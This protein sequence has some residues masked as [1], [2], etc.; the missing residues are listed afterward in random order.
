MTPRT[1]KAIWDDLKNSAQ[2]YESPITFQGHNQFSTNACNIHLD[3]SSQKLSAE[4][5]QTLFEL[6]HVCQFSSNIRSMMRGDKLNLS[7][8]RPALHTALRARP[9]EVIFVDFQNIVPKVLA[10]RNQIETIAE[11]IRAKRWFG[12]SGKPIKDIVNVGIGGS[13][14]G[15]YFAIHA[16]KN[17]CTEELGYH[18]IS[19]VSPESFYNVIEK[20]NP[21]TTLFIIS[22]KSFTTPE[23]IHNAQKAIEWIGQHELSANHFIAITACEDK[24]RQ[25]GIKNIIPI[26]DWVGG[27]F[28]FCSAI[29]L[30]TA[31]AI[32][33]EQF[34]SLI[35]GAHQ[36]DQHVLEADDKSNMPLLLALIGIWNINF[37]NIPSLVILPYA[38]PFEFFVPFIQQMDMESN[39][40]SID[41][42]GRN[43][44]HA[45][46]PIIW[47]G[48]GNNAQHSY[49]QLLCQG[50]HK[51][52]ADFISLTCH[53]GELI[54]S[55]CQSRMHVLT[56]GRKL[57]HQPSGHIQGGIPLNHIQLSDCTPF[58]IGA[59][60]AL[61]E[62]KIFIQSVVWNTNPFDQP[63]VE[64]AKQEAGL[65][66]MV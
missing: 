64:S 28:S 66:A 4:I 21:E 65:A 33:A 43:I 30:I 31:I 32:G 57:P 18:F 63:G 12:F 17:F 39:G 19:D 54:N 35:N 50:T 56:H 47:G 24:A 41:R 20:L 23:T 29:N 60:V 1:K 27:R 13:H 40:K 16:L 38:R 55:M 8:Q 58:T 7:E 22:S 42:E 34:N 6:A 46:S 62:H 3:Y 36:M 44:P 5:L 11:L 53:S 14:L 61:F 2:A 45:T 48:M 49:F 37:L 25:F 59:L 26:W 15:P 9:H 52:T 51:T 10:A